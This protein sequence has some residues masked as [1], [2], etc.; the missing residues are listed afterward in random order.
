MTS[1]KGTLPQNFIG[2]ITYQFHVKEP[3]DFLRISLE[4]FPGDKKENALAYKEQLISDYKKASG[5]YF[6]EENL[7][8]LYNNPKTEIQLAAFLNG[9]FIGN[10]HNPLDNKD[11]YFGKNCERSRG[12]L[13]IDTSIKGHLKIIINSYFVIDKELDFVLTVSEKENEDV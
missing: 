1:F 11:M 9:E 3:T 4:T 7:E 5:E 10:Q 2:N 13:K 12:C 8:K 6:K